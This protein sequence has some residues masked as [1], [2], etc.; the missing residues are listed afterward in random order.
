MNNPNS[1]PA[2]TS[3]PFYPPGFGPFANM[4]GV[5]GTST[6]RPPNLSVINNPLFTSV[7]PTIVGPHSTVQKNMGEPSHDLL[8]PSEMTFKPPN[9]HYH[10]YQHNSPIVIEKIVNN[11]EQEEMARKVRSLEQS[12]RNMQGLGGPKSVSYKD[13]CMFPYVHLLIGFKNP[14]IDK[15]EGHG[16]PVAHLK[17]F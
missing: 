7:A 4:P 10:A 3:D 1:D 8:Y 12:M 13:L 17:K 16:N 14:K 5:A 9:Q 15:Y 2:Q 11:E 6:M